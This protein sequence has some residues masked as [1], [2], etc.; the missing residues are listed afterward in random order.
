MNWV[1][2][3]IAIV[4]LAAIV[5]LLV[6]TVH[7]RRYRTRM[8]ET[9]KA[10]SH[11]ESDSL[12]NGGTVMSRRTGRTR[13]GTSVSPNMAATHPARRSRKKSRFKL[14]RRN[15]ARHTPADDSDKC[16]DSQNRPTDAGS[17]DHTTE[18]RRSELPQV[19]FH[20]MERI[21]AIEVKMRD[22]PPPIPREIEPTKIKTSH[23]GTGMRVKHP[24][25]ADA[26]RGTPEIPHRRVDLVHFSVTS[27]PTLVPGSSH[28]LDVWAHLADQREQALARAR[29]EADNK[30]VRIKTEGPV[31]VARGSSLTVRL[32]IPD[33]KVTEEKPILWEGDIGNASFLVTV[34]SRMRNGSHSGTVT[35]LIEKMPIAKLFF[36]VEIAWKGT[37]VGSRGIVVTKTRAPRLQGQERRYSS[38]FASYAREDRPEVLSRIQG[39]QKVLPSLD[40]F[41]DVANLRSGEH[42]HARLEE[43]IV[44][45][46]VFYLF[47]SEA[48]SRSE[49]V[50]WE[51]RCALRERGIDFI[52]PCPLAPPDRVPPPK[53]LAD[54][55]HF[56]DWV[57]SYKSCEASA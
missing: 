32:Q 55:L 17:L 26:C 30:K 42:W 4:A 35:I 39:M 25:D 6:L 50:D 47:W 40:V 44:G 7:R 46:D 21:D 9:E 31:R 29:Q 38:A 27:P 24:K 2:I 14:D 52:D 36:S 10:V 3:L 34:P 16:V 18:V 13:H 33:A 41:M 11:R 51:W 54:E 12:D 8:E 56:N 20:K 53:E 5:W 23:Y 1:L 48:A 15:R 19:T 45:R 43:E 57:L 22:L 49:W 37:R 28:I